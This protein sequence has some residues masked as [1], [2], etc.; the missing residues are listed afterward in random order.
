MLVRTVVLSI[1]LQFKRTVVLSIFI[2][3]KGRDQAQG[4]PVQGPAQDGTPAQEG[5]PAPVVQPE[6]EPKA[7]Y[8]DVS[9]LPRHKTLQ[10][11]YP[12]ICAFIKRVVTETMRE[13]LEQFCTKH[14]VPNSSSVFEGWLLNANTTM[15]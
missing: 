2:Q 10:G 4:T 15:K 9:E 3:F 6:V 5:T 11:D 13:K 1:F 7:T 12:K 8:A 14:N